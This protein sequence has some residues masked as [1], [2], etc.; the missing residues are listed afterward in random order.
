MSLKEEWMPSLMKH[1]PKIK[2]KLNNNQEFFLNENKD[3]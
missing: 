3:E 2:D 1:L